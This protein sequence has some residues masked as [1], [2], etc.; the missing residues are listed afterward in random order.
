MASID[1]RPLSVLIARQIRVP[2]NGNI[3]GA[4]SRDHRCADEQLFDYESGGAARED[5]GS[6][7]QRFSLRSTRG[8]VAEGPEELS[9]AFGEFMAFLDNGVTIARTSEVELHHDYFRYSWARYRGGQIEMEGCD[10]G[11]VGDAGQPKRLVV[12]DHLGPRRLPIA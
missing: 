12:F 5:S 8:F 1:A 2:L 11:W 4:N 3:R 10:F 7:R 6:R 9:A